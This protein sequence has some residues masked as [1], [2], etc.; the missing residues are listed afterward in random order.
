MYVRCPDCR[1]SIELIE[2]A[3]L[4]RIAC[5]TC[6]S[7]FSLVGD[8]PTM[9]YERGEDL[10]RGRFQLLEHLGSGKF[11]DVWKAIDTELDRTVAV[12]IPRHEQLGAMQSA[13]FLREA[14]AAAQLKHANIVSVHEIGRDN[15]TIFIVCDYIQGANLRQWLSV[16]QPA[17]TDA[18]QICIK[19]ADALHHA[20]ESGVV[21]RDLKPGN[22]MMDL[23]GEPHVMDFGL[24]KR[25]AVDA[26]MT[27]DGQIVGTPAYMSP[28]QAR[29]EGR[30]VDR[31]ADIY[32]LGVVLFEL[33]TGQ[34]PFRGGER[35]LM[36]QIIEEPPPSLRAIKPAI[37]RDLELI[38]HKCLE[39]DPEV[40]YQTAADLAH[41]LASVLEGR[42]IAVRP[43]T[44]A[45]KSRRW[46]GRPARIHEFTTLAMAVGLLG[47]I[48]ILAGV[49]PMAFGAGPLPPTATTLSHLAAF[50]LMLWM[51][52]F[53]GGLAI[54]LA[55][56][57]MKRTHLLRLIVYEGALGAF[58]VVP[59][60][61]KGYEFG[62]L[63]VADD[64]R[65]FFFS[66]CVLFNAIILLHGL[67][68]YLAAR[69]NA[70]AQ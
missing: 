43:L 13:L 1:N 49:I 2:T 22:I 23:D 42:P 29:G 38:C 36:V 30:Q 18:V 60:Y 33:L 19:L 46:L 61:L 40:R 11:G 67:L 6:H 8:D 52:W 64:M 10:S 9:V 32:S 3:T 50:G 15:Q 39:K 4:D 47:I 34:L 62:G 31:R 20:H 51:P 68:I 70:F 21:H 17:V 16:R 45:Q 37:P 41:D 5:P 54:S 55:P 44:P 48:V 24:S 56:P 63:N 59:A 57:H 66:L 69:R 65:S 58:V 53:A 7:N 25:E 27:L 35:M 14:R 12:K 28:E 26:T